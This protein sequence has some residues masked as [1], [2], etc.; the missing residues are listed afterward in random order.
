MKDQAKLKDYAKLVVEV[1]VNVQEGEPVLITCPVEAV[2]FARLLATY[3]Y[4]RGASEVIMNWKDD[5]LTR[6]K[7][8]NAPMEVFENIP[9]W[10]FDRAKYYY[11]KG[12]NIISVYSEDPE[13]LQGID[14]AKI[15]AASKANNT[16]MKPL[17]KYTMNDIV[18]WCVVSI[19][20]VAWAKKIYPD[21][22][23]EEEAVDKL[24][25]QIFDVTR[26]NEEDPV[27]AWESHLDTLTQKADKLNE[28]HLKSLHYKSSNGTDLVVELPEKHIWMSA[29]SNNAKGTRF[30]PNIPTEEVFTLPSRTGVNGKLVS[31]KPLAYNGNLIDGFTL[32]F[33]D[34]EVVEFTAKKGGEALKSLFDEDPNGRR[35]GEVAL[36]PYDSP[37]SNSN[38]LF[39]NTLFDENASCHFAFGA[40]YPT[41]LEGGTEMSEE[42]I[43]EAGGNDSLL[44]EDFMVGAEDMSITGLTYDG[45]T[46]DIFVDGNFA[47]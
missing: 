40:C 18:S 6:L 9:D 42:E 45:E 39:Y 27:A 24:W 47:I 21:I 30:L 10:A 37:I 32:D 16:K 31:T 12:A 3:S 34:G 8:E 4:E 25:D 38:L 5:P 46:I 7:Y 14:M 36:V 44:H 41:T 26:M 35:L 29:T 43:V 28:L 2:E 13:L 1:G 22:E 23:N 19:P 33:K 15:A 17:D 11:E 20:N